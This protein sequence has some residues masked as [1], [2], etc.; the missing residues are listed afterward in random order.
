MYWKNPVTSTNQERSIK[1]TI[2]I[3]FLWMVAS[4]LIFLQ[5]QERFLWFFWRIEIFYIQH[6]PPSHS[7]NNMSLH[8]Q[9]HCCLIVDCYVIISTITENDLSFFPVPTPSATIFEENQLKIITFSEKMVHYR[10]KPRSFLVSAA[11]W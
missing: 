6:R 1:I 3:L 11:M 5:Q 7:L 2:Q 10:E 4:S 9:K 8:W